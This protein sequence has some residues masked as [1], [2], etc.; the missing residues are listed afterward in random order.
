VSAVEADKSGTREEKRREEKKN[1]V[2]RKKVNR[3]LEISNSMLG[4]EGEW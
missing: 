3:K 1:G 4:R 2:I